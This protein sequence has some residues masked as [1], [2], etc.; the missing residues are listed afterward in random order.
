[1]A[2]PYVS[3][4]DAAA[5]YRPYNQ[6]MSPG[7]Q[8]AREPFRVRNAV[9]G[10]LLL[11]FAAGV[12]AY[13]VSAVKQDVFDDIDEEARQLARERERSL[14]GREAERKLAEGAAKIESAPAAAVVQQAG[15]P[16]SM[17][18]RGLLAPLLARRF[19]GLLDPATKT[20]V[21]GA[22]SVDSIGKLGDGRRHQS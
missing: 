20:L 18:G 2:D 3:R 1:M 14:E 19:P 16:P 9:T 4:K 12:W 7:L 6:L 11:A 13:S 15:V 22:P 8:R 10:T 5:S 17:A 21:W